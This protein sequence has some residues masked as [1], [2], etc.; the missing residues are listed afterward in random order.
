MEILRDSLYFMDAI[1]AY[2]VLLIVLPFI[3]FELPR[4]LLL[5]LS[6][7]L[8]AIR[9]PKYLKTTAK[10][11]LPNYT[12]L[13]VGHNEGSTIRS[14]VLAIREQSHPP[15]Q[16]I[17]V[18]DGSTDNMKKEIV[19]LA[20]EGLID[21]AHHLDLRGG[22]PAALNLGLR[23]IRNEFAVVLD[24]DCTLEIH[25]MRIGLEGFDDERVGMVS[26]NVVPANDEKNLITRMQAIEYFISINLG[27]YANNIINQV[28][29]S[30]GAFT[31]FRKRALDDVFG[32]D[33]G[34]GEDLDISLKMR[35]RN[36]EI[37]FETN[38]IC[39]TRVPEN[40][41]TLVYQR[42]RWESDAI[43]V[44]YKKYTEMV[45]P[46][47]RR[48][49]IK[50]VVHQIE[51]FIYNFVAAVVTPFY[52]AFLIYYFEELAPIALVST[53]IVMLANDLVACLF[54]QWINQRISFYKHLLSMPIYTFYTIIFMRHLRLFAYLREWFRQG[55][56]KDNYVPFKVREFLEE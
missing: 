40:W 32:Y 26:G 11:V 17:V 42:L 36:W 44:R 7:A 41:T 8:S 51:F 35:E 4:Y 10:K 14:T 50:D 30:S 52:L 1:G 31:I 28:S 47:D 13:I 15:E 48:F 33:S 9:S 20:D 3:V 37:R 39:F 46:A 22:K 16:I 12:S 55:V 24:C 19:K 56:S 54:A 43:F 6:G 21:L 38:A 25:A 5:F 2:G 29:L 53:Y 27:R 34:R 23:S 18:S 49:S 45:N